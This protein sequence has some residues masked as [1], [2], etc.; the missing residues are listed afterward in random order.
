MWHRLKRNN[1]A[2]LGLAV[3]GISVVIALLGY[4]IT[5]DSTPN[6]NLQFPEL[7]IKKPG[8]EM[9]F[10]KVRKNEQGSDAGFFTRMQEGEPNN[11]RLIPMYDYFF[12]ENDIV[13]EQ[14]TGSDPNNGPQIRFNLADV[15]YPI[16]YNRPFTSYSSR[17]LLEFYQVGDSSIISRPIEEL[18]VQLEK[19]NIVSR[20]YWLGTDRLGRDLLSRL[21]LGTRVSLT[22]G[23]ISVLISLVIGVVIGATGG[24]FRGWI[25]DVIMWVVNVVWSIPTLL[26]VIAITLVLG[27]GLVQVF[28]AVGLTMWVD[29]A[30]VVRGQTLALREQEFIEAGRA[31][32]F[33]NARLIFRHVLPNILGPMAVI[34]ADNFANAILIEA[35][36]SFLGLGAQPPTPSWGA[37]ISEHRPYITTDAAYLAIIPGLAIMLMVLAFVMLGNGLRDAV[38][39]KAQKGDQVLGY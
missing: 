8:F 32:G 31:L 16:D 36:L 4:L 34:C 39:V 22:V 14:Y 30:R 5:P 19:E 1:S 33:T 7:N 23:L 28:I 9:K 18:R 38:D 26:L 35:G 12:E 6:G 24:F 20:K 15:I 27:K 3:I 21:L 25:D 37:M 13:V 11:Y 17:G 2:M 10:L 29:V